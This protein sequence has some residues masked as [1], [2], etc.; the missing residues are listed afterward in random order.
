MI[1]INITVQ[2]EKNKMIAPK[3]FGFA[4][5]EEAIEKLRYLYECKQC[6]LPIIYESG[7]FWIVGKITLTV[8]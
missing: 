8:E 7:E 1:N 4:S 2:S 3:Y 5:M 6:N